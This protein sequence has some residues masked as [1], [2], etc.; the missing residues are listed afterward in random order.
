MPVNYFYAFGGVFLVS[1]ISLIGVLVLAVNTNRLKRAI[2]FLVALATGALFGDVALHLLPEIFESSVDP[3]K[4]SLAILAG[5]LLFFALEKFLHW[6]HS[7]ELDECLE[8]D[9]HHPTI[10]PLG[11]L[12]LVSDGLHNLIDGLIIGVSFLAGIEV[13]LATT[14][15]VILHEIPQEIGDFGILLHAGFSKGQALFFNFLSAVLAILGTVIALFFASRVES[16][17]PLLLAFTAGGFLY[18]AGSDLVPELHKTTE[19][20]RSLIQFLALLLGIFV[21][22]ALLWLE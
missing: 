21:M 18:L 16:L 17:T 10:K 9:H 20:R 8:A 14:L 3:A 6:T 22:L 12:N 15:A 1:L 19:P 7:H 5:I 11:Y 13:G 2:F 4:L